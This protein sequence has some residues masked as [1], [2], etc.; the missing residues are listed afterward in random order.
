MDIRKLKKFKRLDNTPH[1]LVGHEDPM[2][3]DWIFRYVDKEWN[4]YSRAGNPI[5]KDEMCKPGVIYTV[6]IHQ[7]WPGRFDYSYQIV[8]ARPDT[9]WQ[10]EWWSNVKLRIIIWNRQHK[11]YADLIASNAHNGQ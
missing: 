5:T 1:W 10:Y 7:E 11:E 3:Y 9:I 4:Y 8:W 2:W 6:I